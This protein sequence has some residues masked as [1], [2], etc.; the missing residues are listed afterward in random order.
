[1]PIVKPVTKPLVF[2]KNLRYTYRAIKNSVRPPITLKQSKKIQI[3][4][5]KTKPPIV[6]NL[7]NCETQIY[8]GKRRSRIDRHIL[9]KDPHLERTFLLDG[10]NETLFDVSKEGTRKPGSVTADLKKID[11]A[12]YTYQ[13]GKKVITNG[14]L[15]AIHTHPG[16]NMTQ[17]LP[18]F[19]DIKGTYIRLIFD[20]LYNRPYRRS[21]YSDYNMIVGYDTAN[22]RISGRTI[23]KISESMKENWLRKYSL[24][25]VI[26]DSVMI[27]EKNGKYSSISLNEF[28]KRLGTHYDN[29]IKKMDAKIIDKIKRYRSKNK[30][31]TN[32]EL[33]ALDMQEQL[34]YLQRYFGVEIHFQA[35]PGYKLNHETFH[36]EK[37]D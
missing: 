35:E 36:F 27:K 16:I 24:S 15:L 25:S 9:S 14:K 31:A 26:K 8:N 6:L 21:L 4:N 2:R 30:N 29:L 34:H 32:S 28:Q 3:Y 23:Y 17:V 18:S 33:L 11:N 5:G 7:G 1:M 19:N 10:K 12:H 22:K 37:I 20:H 13:K